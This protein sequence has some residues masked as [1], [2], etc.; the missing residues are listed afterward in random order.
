MQWPRS[1][2]SR[3]A[4]LPLGLAPLYVNAEEAPPP[5]TYSAE[6]AIG[7]EYDTNVTIDELDTSIRQG[8]HA[9]TLDGKVGLRKHFTGDTDLRLNYNFS[10]D[11]FQEFSRLNRQTHILGANLGVKMQ[12]LDTGLSLFYV[13]SLLDGKGFLELY[14]VSPSL[15]GFINRKVFTRAAYIF[16]DKRIND[17]SE[18]DAQT[19]TGELDLYYFARGLRSYF[20]IGYRFRT[21]HANLE[22]LDYEAHAAKL[23]YIRRIDFRNR[24]LKLEL[25]YRYEERDY[26]GITPGIGTGEGEERGDERHR[27]QADLEYPLS[28]HSALQVYAGYSDYKSNFPV[29]DY[30]QGVVGTRFIYRW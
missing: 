15:S 14:R 3:L 21:E 23:R 27:W 6:F 17:R 19:H 20:N 4:V 12:P 29:S 22:R 5:T 9:L 1:I 18:R 25:A 2:L 8:D 11:M 24:V 28:S 26:S 7:G 30:E 13:N 16:A 10:Q